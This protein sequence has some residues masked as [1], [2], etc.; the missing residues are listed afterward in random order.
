[1][2]PWLTAHAHP[3]R[4][5][6]AKLHSAPCITNH[7]GPPVPPPSFRD[8]Q[9]GI[10]FRRQRQRPL[11]NS[12]LKEY[13]AL[14][15]RFV[16][17]T[18]SFE[19]AG[20][21]SITRLKLT[22]EDREAGEAKLN[23][24]RKERVLGQFTASALAGNAVLGSV[25]YALPAVVAV[26]GV[27]SPIS[28]FIATLILFLWR[29]IMEELASALP[30][31]GAPYTYILNVSTKSLALV[32]ASLLL[33]DFASTAVVSAATAAT[34]L[35]GE[36]PSLPFPIWVGAAIVLFL[37]TII[38]LTGIKE[39]ARIALIVLALHMASMTILIIASSVHWGQIGIDQFKANWE[40]GRTSNASAGSVAK[41]IYYGFCLG[42][43]GLTGFECIPAYISRIKPG[44]FPLVLRNLHIPAIIL[45]TAMMILVLAIV[46]L[47][48]IKGG[49]NVLSILAQLAGGRWLRIWIVIDAIVVLCGG[50]LT[51]ILS[52]CEL[53]EQ[54]A[55]HRVLPNFFLRLLPKT[56][57]PFVSVLSFAAFSSA[58]YASAGTSLNIISQMFSLVWLTVMSF[59]PISLLLLRFNRGRIRRD[60]PISLVVIFIA[61]IIVPAV[62]VGNIAVNPLTAAYFA[63]YFLGIVVIFT[64][65]QN[66]IYLL[67]WIYWTYDQYPCLHHC[68]A[69]MAWGK[70]LINLMTNLRRQPVCILVKTDE[71][72]HLFHMI[73]YVQKNE[74]TSY[75][76]IVHF[77]D[78]EFGVPSELEANAK[79]LD[80]A[81]PEITIDLILIDAVFE[82]TNV[83]ALANHLKIPTS[84][85]FMTCPGKDFP[86]SMSELGTRIISL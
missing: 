3:L 17:L 82:P 1:M 55:L 48:I 28:L 51:G 74:E 35:A 14:P 76:K 29:P 25:F 60:S 73:L 50:V 26:G 78:Q 52:A 30:I 58:L 37:F 24:M 68:R 47:D 10:I 44:K 72:N 19:F 65:T 62:L 79:I 5:L 39:S 15:S 80:E 11:D 53:L 38:S 27:Y 63:A 13:L 77:Y 49:A 45:N 12:G 43:L 67:R 64:A 36:V 42:M 22:R 32:G 84:V 85:M 75:L 46:P 56:G 86:Y 61:L 16:N 41:Q 31:S 66:K 9:F 6:P 83:A 40:A 57:S 20:W 54:L 18:S 21:G 71:I 33:L 69:T 23:K 34:Y 4:P 7:D 81:F 70:I 2:S 59:F 8:S